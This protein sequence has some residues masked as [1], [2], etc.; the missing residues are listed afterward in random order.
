MGN[1]APV[2]ITLS[3][4]RLLRS[5][6]QSTIFIRSHDSVNAENVIKIILVRCVISPRRFGEKDTSV[7]APSCGILKIQTSDS[8]ERDK[9]RPRHGH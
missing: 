9:K 7:E 4:P 3:F 5:F 6:F 8:F 2:T 1:R